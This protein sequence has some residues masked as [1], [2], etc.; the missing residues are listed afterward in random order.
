MQ[1]LVKQ[2]VRRTSKVQ[3]KKKSSTLP[4]ILKL[5]CIICNCEKNALSKS[6]VSFSRHGQRVHLTSI[7]A[8]FPQMQTVHGTGPVT[9]TLNIQ[10]YIPFTKNTDF[11]NSFLQWKVPVYCLF[12]IKR[13]KDLRLK[14]TSS[15]HLLHKNQGDMEMSAAIHSWDTT[16]CVV[17]IPKRLCNLFNSKYRNNKCTEQYKVV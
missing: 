7:D 11:L 15:L 10:L 6:T 9:A 17:S 14:L 1:I 12:S 8:F 2:G 4:I 5:F 3:K 16:N 13:H